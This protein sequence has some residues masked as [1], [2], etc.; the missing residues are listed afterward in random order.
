MDAS[1]LHVLSERQFVQRSR[2]RVRLRQQFRRQQQDSADHRVRY[3]GDAGRRGWT[4]RH[5]AAA[6][7]TAN[8]DGAGILSAVLHRVVLDRRQLALCQRLCRHIDQCTVR[9]IL[10][11]QHARCAQL[12]FLCRQYV[13][14]PPRRR[15]GHSGVRDQR[16]PCHGA[17]GSDQS[18]N[19]R[20]KRGK[21]LAARLGEC[22]F[23]HSGQR[24]ALIT[25]R[26][27]GE[28]CVIRKGP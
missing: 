26:R 13:P 19:K 5:Y 25:D 23:V 4:Q 24:R 2:S 9:I 27:L 14:S 6:G 16:K 22:Q 12:Q 21:R 28:P 3:P 8:R 18:D 1:R 15:L 20:W 11:R 10:P 7:V 17:G